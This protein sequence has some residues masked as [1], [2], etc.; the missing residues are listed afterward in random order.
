MRT[1]VSGPWDGL[2]VMAGIL[3]SV[4][5]L[6]LA[7]LACVSCCGTA[8]HLKGFDISGPG[9]FVRL[10][11]DGMEVYPQHHAAICAVLILPGMHCLFAVGLASQDPGFPLAN[12][13]MAGI[14]SPAPGS[15]LAVPT[16]GPMWYCLSLLEI[17][18]SQDLCR[19]ES[20]DSRWSWLEFCLH[21]QAWTWAVLTLFFLCHYVRTLDLTIMP[22]H[23]AL[24][25]MCLLWLSIQA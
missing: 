23:L 25:A 17:L 19:V 22:F 12:L 9:L 14:L 4:P 18:A 21:L 10:A 8:S 15:N 3:C 5:G 20:C 24:A 6:N 13:A 2:L 11:R 16:C 7:V 1:S